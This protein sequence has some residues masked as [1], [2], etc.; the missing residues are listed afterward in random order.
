M[1]VLTLL[2]NWWRRLPTW[3]AHLDYLPIWP[4]L[5][6]LSDSWEKICEEAETWPFQNIWD[7]RGTKPMFSW[8]RVYIYAFFLYKHRH[9]DYKIKFWGFQEKTH[10]KNNLKCFLFFFLTEM[11][12]GRVWG[13]FNLKVPLIFERHSVCV[14]IFENS[15]QNLWR[16]LYRLTFT[17]ERIRGS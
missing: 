15:D 13:L 16:R 14:P 11:T 3:G 12:I 1:T 10:D 17:F 8:I 5:G 4:K 2:Q 9:I 6:A 7:L